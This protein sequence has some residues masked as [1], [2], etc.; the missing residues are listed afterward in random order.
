MV[1]MVAQVLKNVLRAKYHARLIIIV[2]GG[3]VNRTLLTVKYP[4]GVHGVLAV[5]V[6]TE[7]KQEEG[8]SL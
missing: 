5:N 4:D 2:R 8:V 3:D 7:Q 1:A 6:M